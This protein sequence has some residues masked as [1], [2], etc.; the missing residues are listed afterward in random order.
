MQARIH[1][2]QDQGKQAAQKAGADILRAGVWIS[3]KAIQ[4]DNK[5]NPKKPYCRR[6]SSGM[7]SAAQAIDRYSAANPFSLILCGQR[8]R[9]VIANKNMENN[10]ETQV[11]IWFLPL[12]L[13]G[14]SIIPDDRLQGKHPAKMLNNRWF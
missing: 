5:Q 11:L 1:V 9:I 8:S 10:K 14:V 13:T 6:G 12:N 3:E 2:Y 4:A 7:V